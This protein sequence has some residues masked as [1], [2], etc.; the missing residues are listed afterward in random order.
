[1]G[2]ATVPEKVAFPVPSKEKVVVLPA[3]GLTKLKEDAPSLMVFAAV[4][5]SMYDPGMPAYKIEYDGDANAGPVMRP[6]VFILDAL[7]VDVF[8]V[9]RFAKGAVKRVPVLIVPAFTDPDRK[10]AT[11]VTVPLINALP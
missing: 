5:L 3:C 7:I 10:P 9:V 4:P 2:A 1:M 8:M 11:E 6:E